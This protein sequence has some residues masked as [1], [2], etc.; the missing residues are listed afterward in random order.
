MDVEFRTISVADVPTEML[1][2]QT[3]PALSFMRAI[4]AVPEFPATPYLGAPAIVIACE[5]SVND[6]FANVMVTSTEA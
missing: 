1:L 4:A 3:V 6:G 2:T 5:A